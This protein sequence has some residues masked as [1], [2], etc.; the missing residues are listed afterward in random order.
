MS[1]IRD[2]AMDVLTPVWNLYDLLPG[3]RGSWMPGHFYG[4]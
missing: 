4:G 1:T 2:R 3:G